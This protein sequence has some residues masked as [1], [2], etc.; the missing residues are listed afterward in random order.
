MNDALRPSLEA[1]LAEWGRRVQANRDQVERFREVGDGADFYA[2]IAAMFRADPSRQDE[3]A[4]NALRQLVRPEETWL[5]IGA[6]G[7]RYALPIALLAREVIALEP[8]EGML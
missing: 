2:P 4:L 7:G 8:S 5:D 1:A 3:G 6:G